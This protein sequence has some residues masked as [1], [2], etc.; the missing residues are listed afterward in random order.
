MDFCIQTP[1]NLESIAQGTSISG[2][3][4]SSR[5]K[6]T[7]RKPSSKRRKG[8]ANSSTQESQASVGIKAK[9]AK[10]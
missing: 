7:Y 5:K 10:S 4:S 2:V 8:Q 1:R 9:K 6:H 3:T